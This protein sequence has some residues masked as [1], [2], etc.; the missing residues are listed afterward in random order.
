MNFVVFQGVLTHVHKMRTNA[1][2]NCSVRFHVA[3]CSGSVEKQPVSFAGND[4]NKTLVCICH[5]KLA[6]KVKKELEIGSICTFKGKL[7][8]FYDPYADSTSNG[9]C[10][11]EISPSLYGLPEAFLSST[12]NI[13][14]NDVVTVAVE[15]TEAESEDFDFSEV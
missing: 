10:I 14:E 11:T 7:A 8:C 15:D 13:T 5:N 12:T 9:I 2:D 4:L 3:L 1:N 6:E